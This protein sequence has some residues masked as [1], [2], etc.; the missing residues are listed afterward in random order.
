MTNMVRMDVEDGVAVVRID[1]PPV[2]ALSRGVRDG[3]RDAFLKADADETAEAILIVCEGR[4]YIAGAD[5][6]EFGKP[7]QGTSLAEVQAVIEGASKPVISSIHGTALG[8][9]LE[10][11][12]CGHFRVAVQSA[13]FG[14]PEVKLG[15]LPGAGGTQRLSRGRSR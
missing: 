7:L 14:Q 4:T 5:I 8:G 12:M 11:A 2:N 9:G 6:R 15:L 3:L 1:N 13:R 10:V